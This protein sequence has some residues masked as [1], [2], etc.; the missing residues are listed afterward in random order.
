MSQAQ[1]RQRALEA[2]GAFDDDSDEV[3]GP[4]E[5]NAI[6]SRDGGVYYPFPQPVARNRGVTPGTPAEVYFHP[7][8]N[9]LLVVPQTFE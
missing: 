9:V 3:V 8:S 2:V 7:A 6:P 5:R 1:A 4:G